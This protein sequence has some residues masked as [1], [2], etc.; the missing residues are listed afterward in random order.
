MRLASKLVLNR[1]I[2]YDEGWCLKTLQKANM[3]EF[4][5]VEYDE[6]LFIDTIVSKYGKDLCN[7]IISL[8]YVH[9]NGDGCGD[10]GGFF[11]MFFS[12]GVNYVKGKG[13]N[14]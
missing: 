1:R 5:M 9:L 12:S 4:D 6:R 3:I 13:Y 14:D 8:G 10:G 2:G 11:E 7:G